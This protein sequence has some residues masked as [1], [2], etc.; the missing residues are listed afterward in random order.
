MNAVPLD[1]FQASNNDWVI[2]GLLRRGDRVIVAGEPGSGKSTLLWQVALFAASGLHPFAAEDRIPPISVLIVDADNP[3]DLLADKLGRMAE[4]VPSAM[5]NVSIFHRPAGMLSDK[6]WTDLDWAV[7]EQKPDLI[8]AGPLWK[9]SSDSRSEEAASRL[10]LLRSGDAWGP[11][12]V[13]ALWVEHHTHGDALIGSPVWQRWPD[14]GFRLT[15][16]FK[17]EYREFAPY[18]TT[19]DDRAWPDGFV[20]GDVL[21][22][23]PDAD[24]GEPFRGWTG[25]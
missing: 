10:D 23:T 5:G 17:D 18:R 14:F 2:P 7:E 20:M 21:P 9:L 4:R 8:C 25:R 16:G 6:D 24:A 3:S 1:L 11:R 13:P 19:R 22:W 12:P 15:R